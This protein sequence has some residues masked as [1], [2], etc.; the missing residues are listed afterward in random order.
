[1]AR[2]D[3]YD[4]AGK[5]TGKTELP[6][7]LFVG[8]INQILMTQ[9]VRVYLANRR[10]GS[11][12]AKGRSEITSLSTAKVWRQKGTGRARHSSRRAPIFVGG[13]KAHGPTEKQNFSLKLSKKMKQAALIS[14]LT[15]KHRDKTVWVIKDLEKI[16]QKT[17]LGLKTLKAI[18]KDKADQ[19]IG[20]VLPRKPGKTVR[21]FRN[22]EQVDLYSPADLNTYSTLKAGQLI[23]TKQSLDEL[24]ERFMKK[25]KIK[26]LK[27]K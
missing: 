14:A 2:I 7:K 12:K 27:E 16:K 1:M 11:A 9:A 20:L 19:K 25:K 24:K 8:K 6:N 10:V 5:K 23:F 18:L 3:L 26:K 13:G 21:S 22:L 17:K 4:M 15:L